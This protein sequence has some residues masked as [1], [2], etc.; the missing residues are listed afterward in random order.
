MS[1]PKKNFCIASKENPATR[2]IFGD[3]Y[4]EPITMRRPTSAEK[5]SISTRHLGQL[6]AYGAD[7]SH[8]NASLSSLAYIFCLLDVLCVG[9]R[10]DWTLRDNVFDEDE[11][12]IFALF[13]EVSL[14]LETFRP[15]S[16]KPAGS[17]EGQ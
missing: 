8:I 10:P 13:E 7:P 2:Q 17:G 15:K 16:G 3:K 9:E 1:A 5:I 11:P 4:G 6:S 14:W 12:A